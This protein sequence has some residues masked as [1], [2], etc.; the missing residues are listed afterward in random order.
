MTSKEEVVCN[1]YD[2]TKNEKVIN[3]KDDFNV[4]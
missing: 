3:S 2:F 4:I 1:E